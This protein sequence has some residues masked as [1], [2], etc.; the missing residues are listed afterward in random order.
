MVRR[1]ILAVVLSVAGSWVPCSAQHRDAED[2][3]RVPAVPDVR[4]DSLVAFVSDSQSPLFLET[5]RLSTNHND[6]AREMIYA[7]ILADRPDAVFHL[8]DMVSIGPYRAS[9][10]STDA[11][12]EKARTARIPVFAT[13]GNHELMFLPSYGMEEFLWRF[14][15]Y[16]KTGYL[17]RVGKLAVVL[18]NS[19]FGQL[20]D[21]DQH[22]QDSWL[23]STL[24]CLQADSTVGAVMVACHHPPYTNSTIVSPSARVRETFVSA[25]LR[26]PK[27]VLFLT[28]HCHAC[29][30]FKQDGKD[31][32]VLGGGGGLQQPLL[33]GKDVRWT[34]L[35]PRK[36]ELRMFHYV[37]C[38]ITPQDLRVTVRMVKEDFSG[39][40]DAYTL[41]FPF[42]QTTSR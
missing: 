12:L 8:G 34:D 41:T 29:E 10:R 32:L 27:C 23:D 18:L 40:E 2:P 17:V 4:G 37:R 6:V 3:S 30:H 1:L 11:F 38:R 9:W 14:P 16:R 25:Y 26:Y 13:L 15:W 7:Q 36:T 39:F 33:T 19:N 28:G 35:F 24:A 20:S 31:F 22:V 21:R 5:F 42:V